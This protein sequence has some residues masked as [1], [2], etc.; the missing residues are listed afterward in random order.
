LEQAARHDHA[1]WEDIRARFEEDL[2]RMM[3]SLLRGA[4]GKTKGDI[5]QLMLRHQP[6]TPLGRFLRLGSLP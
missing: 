1:K 4:D 2:E 5:C 3:I 6:Q